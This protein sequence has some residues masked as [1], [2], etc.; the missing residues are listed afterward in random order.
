MPLFHKMKAGGAVVFPDHG[1]TL[2]LHSVRGGRAH[3]S[4]STDDGVVVDFYDENG[5]RRGDKSHNAES[6][7]K[8]S[9]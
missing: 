2:N 4:V 7:L 1:I 3:F 9:G 8:A 6:G 5:A